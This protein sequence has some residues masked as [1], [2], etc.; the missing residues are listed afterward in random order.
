MIL[1][2]SV[3]KDI[4]LDP[5][6][7]RLRDRGHAFVRV[8][9][10]DLATSW[11]IICSDRSDGAS[12][13]FTNLHNDK[14]FSWADV[15][16]VWYRRPN[17]PTGLSHELADAFKDFA[18]FEIYSLVQYLLSALD[19]SGITWVSNPH[20]M[21]RANSRFFQTQAARAAGFT[22]PDTIVSN[23]PRAIHGFIQQHR[24]D[25]FAIKRI[26]S[27]SR[28]E[29]NIS[30]FTSRVS[31]A[32]LLQ[33]LDQTS[34]CPTLIQEYVPKVCEY[35]V[36]VIGDRVF[37]CRLLSQENPASSVDW[38]ETN[39]A[40]IKHEIVTR[41]SLEAKALDVIRRL[42]LRFGAIDLIER[43][44]GEI[45]FLEVNPNGQ[46]LWIE[47]ITGAK[48]SDAMTDLLSTNAA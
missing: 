23:H 20:S 31:R 39:P 4:H 16:A 19:A 46:W 45:V 33:K 8:N 42:G 47:Q 38:R 17:L 37:T 35:R 28:L 9:T 6:V 18:A 22:V 24:T 11:L 44:D 13:V 15:T 21:S 29:A 40:F 26:S 34:L 32:E 7:E 2:L 30:F 43:P 36:T 3:Q 12:H 25:L 41:P 27:H 10:D 5:V 48:M 14:S 1:L